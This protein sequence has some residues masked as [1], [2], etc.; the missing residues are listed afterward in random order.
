MK[1]LIKCILYI[2]IFILIIFV[3]PAVCT[4]KIKNK[5]ENKE[6]EIIES[7]KHDYSKYGTIKLLHKESGQIEEISIDEYIYGVISAEMPAK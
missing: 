3:L 2:L 7:Q 4:K 1:S 5:K 6:N